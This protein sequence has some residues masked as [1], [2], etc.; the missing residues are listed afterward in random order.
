MVFWLL[1]YCKRVYGRPTK[2]LLKLFGTLLSRLASGLFR[3]EVI[4]IRESKS[5]SDIS[6]AF[7][8]LATI[9]QRVVLACEKKEAVAISLLPA[10]GRLSSIASASASA[11]K[12]LKVLPRGDSL[13]PPLVEAKYP[14]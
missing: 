14:L 7:K 13:Y 3:L 11:S 2:K 4:R 9:A 1:I 6:S 5:I 12:P 10:S 8:D